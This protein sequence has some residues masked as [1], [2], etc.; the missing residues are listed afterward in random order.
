MSMAA[1]QTCRIGVLPRSFRGVDI[2]VA[3]AGGFATFVFRKADVYR[4]ERAKV[5]RKHKEASDYMT[6]ERAKSG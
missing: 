4:G 6:R 2:T 1:Y 3:A 5:A